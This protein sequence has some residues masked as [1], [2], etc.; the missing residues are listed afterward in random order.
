MDEAHFR[1]DVDL[2]G[3]W[4]L[5]GEPALANSTT[6]VG[7]KATYYSG[8]GLDTGEVESMEV[9]G[10]CNAEA[11]VAFLRQLRRTTLNP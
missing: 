9:S 11:S 5:K 3:K 6:R 10:I 2:R 8:V 4:A 1:A 7:E